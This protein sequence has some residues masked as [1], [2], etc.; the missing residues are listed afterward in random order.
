MHPI[1]ISI[2]LY[3]IQIHQ[4]TSVTTNP[5]QNQDQVQAES[6]FFP[7]ESKRIHKKLKFPSD[8]EKVSKISFQTSASEHLDDIDEQAA[9]DLILAA[10]KSGRSLDLGEGTEEL[11]ELTNDPKIKAEI[12]AGNDA[13]ARNYIRNKLCKLGLME[14][15]RRQALNFDSSF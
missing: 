13:Q 15:K 3:L 2:L 1:S 12:V 9:I 8:E 11:R 5:N 14:V 6:T 7:S 10:T 4:G